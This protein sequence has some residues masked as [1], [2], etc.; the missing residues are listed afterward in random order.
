MI[1]CKCIRLEDGLEYAVID[2]IS[3]GKDITYVYLS[4]TSN[5]KD[6]CI[7]KVDDK[8]NPELLVGLD[9]NEEFDKALLLFSKKHGNK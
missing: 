2:E 7:R 3:D 4:N 6:F 1:D 5:E 8:V 9:S